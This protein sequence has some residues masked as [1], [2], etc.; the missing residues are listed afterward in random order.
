MTR[1]PF[2]NERRPFDN[3]PRLLDIDASA[4]ENDA[5]PCE[6]V[7]VTLR[8]CRATLRGCRVTLR[9]CRVTLRECRV[10]LRELSG[11]HA[12][13]VQSPFAN[14]LQPFNDRAGRGSK[15]DL[16]FA[17]GGVDIRE[18]SNGI[19]AVHGCIRCESRD[20]LPQSKARPARQELSP[21]SCRLIFLGG[22]DTRVCAR[23]DRDA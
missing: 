19:P 5:S 14:S 10:T 15:L 17:K 20:N 18:A 8:E 9:E 22:T 2:Q 4:F 23:E 3:D 16:S 1:H 13:V 21:T 6:S 12:L 7:V 11:T